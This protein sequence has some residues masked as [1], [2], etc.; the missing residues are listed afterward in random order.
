V[1]FQ[2][3]LQAVDGLFTKGDPQAEASRGLVATFFPGPKRTEPPN[4]PRVSTSLGGLPQAAFLRGS[5]S[6]P[7]P[8]TSPLPFST[9][10]GGLVQG[11]PT[12]PEQRIAEDLFLTRPDRLTSEQSSGSLGGSD[13][14][15]SV[16]LP[17]AG[18]FEG[19]SPGEG[20]ARAYDKAMSQPER[21]SHMTLE[22]LKPYFDLPIKEACKRL[23]VGATVRRLSDHYC[24]FFRFLFPP[25]FGSSFRNHF[26]SSVFHVLLPCPGESVRSWTFAAWP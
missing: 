15:S 17:S 13:V 19:R 3:P 11:A 21:V 18:G 6:H 24:P 22:T 20:T 25:S 2:K 1:S 9:L 8:K 4:L 14:L 5:H 23:R 26:R 12:A 7:F 10:S 16:E